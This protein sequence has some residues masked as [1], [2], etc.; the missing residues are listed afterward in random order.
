M[1]RGTLCVVLFVVGALAFGCKKNEEGAAGGGG[2]GGQTLASFQAGPDY[3]A[4]MTAAGD[5]A[6]LIAEDKCADAVPKAKEALA[7]ILKLVPDYGAIGDAAKSDKALS[8]RMSELNAAR[9]TLE[10]GLEGYE[11]DPA[12]DL[13]KIHCNGI[14]DSLAKVT[15]SP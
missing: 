13:A 6:R 7:L 4:L 9:A 8:D 3:A 14:A 10:M 1:S 5:A 2:G 12:S 15:G 11:E